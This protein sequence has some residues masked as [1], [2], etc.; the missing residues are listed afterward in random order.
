[1]LIYDFFGMS[2]GALVIWGFLMATLLHLFFYI[3]KVQKNLQ[4]LLA[5]TLLFI[6]YFVSDFIIVSD[7]YN[8]AIHG[9]FAL[10]DLFTLLALF[11]ATYTFFKDEKLEVGV[12]YTMIGLAINTVM[13]FFMY[14]DTYIY[15]NVTR[16]LLWYLYSYLVI[17]VDFIMVTSL[18]VNKDWLGIKWAI[19]KVR[20]RVA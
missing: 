6:S 4:L 1:M 12:L 13:F 10:F 14:I 19:S 3:L 18:L 16:W 2:I 20:A 15:E 11:L 5:S 9:I 8:T 7:S 17:S